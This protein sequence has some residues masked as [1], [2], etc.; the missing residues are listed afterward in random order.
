MIVI[1][2]PCQVESVDHTMRMAERLD[3]I[4]AQL[5]TTVI[6]K[7][8]FDKANRTSG[9]S[10]RG[11]GISVAMA[12][13]QKIKAS[14]DMK[15]VTDVHEPW[16]CAEV[17]EVVDILQIPA[18]LCRQTDLIEA[19]ALTGRGV[20]IKKGQFLAAEDMTHAVS[21]ARAAGADEIFATERGTSF[22]YR[23]L[24]VDMR[25]I[26][27]M[28]QSGADAVIFDCTHAVQTPGS[29]AGATG[30]ER[31]MSEPLA[32][33]AIAAGADGLFLECHDDPASAP[34]DG[35]VMMK[36]DDVSGFLGR[37]VDLHRFVGAYSI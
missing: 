30:G 5:R 29:A 31:A 35:A 4:A 1:A 21:K 24:I 9:G 22:G 34:S 3:A 33:A 26:V 13:F 19:A 11:A 16:Q 28:K 27:R 12:A 32:R 20:N 8:S 23:D 14:F 2:G 36:I 17:C 37:M 6:F 18:L 7:A 15:I 10:P 25:S